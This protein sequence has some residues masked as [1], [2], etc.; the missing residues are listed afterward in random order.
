MYSNGVRNDHR[1]W[2]SGQLLDRARTASLNNLGRGSPAFIAPQAP[3]ILSDPTAEFPIAFG[4]GSPG[5]NRP[6]IASTFTEEDAEGQAVSNTYDIQSDVYSRAATDGTA[7]VYIGD[8]L[9]RV[10]IVDFTLNPV[11]VLGNNEISTAEILGD[12]AITSDGSR[13]FI[14]DNFLDP[15]PGGTIIAVD[16]AE[17]D[18]TPSPT[19]APQAMTMP[20]GVPATM[21]PTMDTDSGSMTMMPTPEDDMTNST[22]EPTASP[23]TAAPTPAPSSSSIASIFVTVLVVLVSVLL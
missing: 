5:A 19:M 21:M 6:F 22:A 11:L 18:R 7:R 1:G 23:V 8:A 10:H 9:G 15:I 16:V 20:T 17:S 12:L 3:F 14:P 2:T 13:I 4:P